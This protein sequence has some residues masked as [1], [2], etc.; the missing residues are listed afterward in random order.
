MYKLADI[1]MLENLQQAQNERMGYGHLAV[2]NDMAVFNDVSVENHSRW[3]AIKRLE[4]EQQVLEKELWQINHNPNM[5]KEMAAQ[6]TVRTNELD[7]RI[8]QIREHI[9]ELKQPKAIPQEDA[10]YPDPFNPEDAVARAKSKQQP[11]NPN[12]RP[13]NGDIP[14]STLNETETETTRR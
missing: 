2:F 12:Q 3:D 11:Y 10:F 9:A 4:K 13:N 8:K 6:Y 7:T 5:N 14:P 1:S